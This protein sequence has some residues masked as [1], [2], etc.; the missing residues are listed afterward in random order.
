V[1]AFDEAVEGVDGIAHTASAVRMTASLFDWVTDD[2]VKRA[3]K[4]TVGLL[5]SIQRNK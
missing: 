2:H 3:V 1:N 4:S 5:N